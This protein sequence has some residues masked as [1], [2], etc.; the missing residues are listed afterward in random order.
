MSL[1]IAFQNIKNANPNPAV[2]RQNMAKA[3][4]MRRAANLFKVGSSVYVQNL[5]AKVLGYNISD[6]G[7]W[8][9]ISHPVVVELETGEVFCCKLSDLSQTPVEATF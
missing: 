5:P 6:F 9:G 2:A 8:L 4:F 1:S 3:R 7:R